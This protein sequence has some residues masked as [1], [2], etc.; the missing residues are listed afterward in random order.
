MSYS[1][2]MKKGK[3]VAPLPNTFFILYIFK[4]WSYHDKCGVLTHV[5]MVNVHYLTCL[6]V[7]LAYFFD[8]NEI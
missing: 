8:Y 2:V 3:S 7:C 5:F 6:N 4:R 1:K